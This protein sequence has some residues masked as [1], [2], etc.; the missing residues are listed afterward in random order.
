MVGTQALMNVISGERYKLVPTEIRDYVLGRYGAA[1]AAIDPD[2]A[3]KV[4]AG[5]P[6]DAEK[7]DLQARGPHRTRASASASRR[8]RSTRAPRR[9]FSA[10][11]SSRSRR[12]TSSAG[13]KTRSTTSPS[14]R[15]V[16]RSPSRAVR[17]SGAFGAAHGAP[18]YFDAASGASGAARGMSNASGASGALEPCLARRARGFHRRYHFL[19]N[20][21]RSTLRRRPALLSRGDAH[22]LEALHAGDRPSPPRAWPCSPS[23]RG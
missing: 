12:A 4:V 1:P 9:T 15:L 20:V 16:S 8:L 6:E 18:C 14:R 22:E 13:G 3:A 10:T 7:I 5:A 21:S 23:Q 11:R 2:V 17:E 19:A